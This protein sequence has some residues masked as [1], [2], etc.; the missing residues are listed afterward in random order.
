MLRRSLALPLIS[1]SVRSTVGDIINSVAT[2]QAVLIIPV[3]F[4]L[5]LLGQCSFSI[6]KIM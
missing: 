3:F 6:L 5:V 4:D 2:C 1:P